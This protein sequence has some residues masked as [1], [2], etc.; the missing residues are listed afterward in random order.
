MWSADVIR[1]SIRKSGQ[2]VDLVADVNAAFAANVGERETTTQ[3]SS[4]QTVQHSRKSSR[5][6]ETSQDDQ[7]QGR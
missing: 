6:A 7:Q 1:R 5:V 4:S 3:V 2:F